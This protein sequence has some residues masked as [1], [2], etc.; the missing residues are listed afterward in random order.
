MRIE[1]G[2]QQIP[3]QEEN[4]FS[5]DSV[6]P[7]L[8][9]RTLPPDVFQEVEPD[10]HHFGHE[11]LTNIRTLGGNGRVG[12]PQLIQYDQWGRRVDEL[13]TSEGWR[14]LKAASQGEGIPAIFYERKHGEHSRLHGFA[15][16]LMMVGDTHGVFCPLSM[17]DGAARVIELMGTP[18]MKEEIL[19]RLTSRDPAVAFTSG[20][21]MTERPGGSDVSQTETIA[22]PVGKET[23]YGPQYEL[24]GFKWFS[25]ATDSDMSVALARTGSVQDGSRGL[26]L[27]LIPLRLPLI[28]SPSDPVPSAMSNNIF[29]HRL[30]SK[31]GTQTLPTAELSLEGTEAY[32]IGPL[33]QGVKCITPV[34]NITRVWSA[35]SSVGGL[36][37]CLSM[38]TSYAKVRAI[39]GGK[40]LLIDDPLHVSQLASINLLY[41]ALTHLVFGAIRLLGK[42]ECGTASPDE[43]RRLRLLTPLVKSFASEKACSGMEDAMTTL[44]GAGYM[45]E[46][47]IG[48]AIRDALV[49]KIWEGTTTVMALDIARAA[50]D[51]STIPA[52]ISWAKD[53]LYSCPAGLKPHV[54]ESIELVLES[55]D[56]LKASY[57]Q[58]ILPLVPRPA[59]ILMGCV[60]SSVYLLEHAIWSYST[61]EPTSDIDTEVFVRWVA[62]GGTRAAIA[63]VKRAKKS[64]DKREVANSSIVFGSTCKPKL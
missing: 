46:N 50:R 26:S 62:E 28:R 42:S 34:L 7:S 20:Q 3:F 6:L 19:P 15:K 59:L 52:F 40:R 31:I 17:T 39:N 11:L 9:K 21:W 35:I 45:E 27:F 51:P 58:P 29:V 30:K 10:L 22:I 55:L 63:D 4:S 60:A 16:V 13:I 24:N 18:A 47:G 33:N 57:Q 14:D 43:L 36:R 23:R 12:L 64:N 56:E 8:L 1:Q 49:E 61:R 2:F 41:R 53:I 37:K 38:A 48:R 32:R 25:S 5:S 54:S 44:G